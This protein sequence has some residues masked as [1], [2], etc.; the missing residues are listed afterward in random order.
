[1]VIKKINYFEIP[2]APEKLINAVFIKKRNGLESRLKELE[3]EGVKQE[4]PDSAEIKANL[5]DHYHN[6]SPDEVTQGGIIEDMLPEEIPV[7]LPRFI[8]APEPHVIIT[9]LYDHYDKSDVKTHWYE[10][11][12]LIPEFENQA[13]AS[14]YSGLYFSSINCIST[15][16]EFILKYEYV[17]KAQPS[18]RNM[19]LDELVAGKLTLGS[20]ITEDPSNPNKKEVI[21]SKARL[22]SSGLGN[23][24]NE[25]ILLNKVRNGFFH[26]NPKKLRDALVAIDLN[27]CGSDAVMHWVNMDSNEVTIEN[28]DEN[29]LLAHYE[30]PDNYKASVT[31]YFSYLILN[32]ILSDL[33]GTHREIEIIKEAIADFDRRQQSIK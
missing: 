19:R 33:Y 5:M 25:L 32:K 21:E 27:R 28:I 6:E 4:L 9:D 23:Y 24:R 18:E 10:L 13:F 1:M 22:E 14:Y 31:A 3:K 16:V 29:Y 30:V 11:R 26:F 8:P 2:M 12:N 15:C 7:P 20:F 17:R